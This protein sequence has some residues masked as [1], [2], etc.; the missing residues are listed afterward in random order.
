M[1]LIKRGLAFAGKVN[2]TGT[3]KNGDVMIDINLDESSDLLGEIVMSGNLTPPSKGLPSKLVRPAEV[4]AKL[5]TKAFMWGLRCLYLED[6]VAVG[7]S[8]SL[9]KLCSRISKPSRKAKHP[10]DAYSVV[11]LSL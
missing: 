6:I 1:L 10:F 9:I 4:S 11:S 2:G 3:I 5:T 8:T 7:S